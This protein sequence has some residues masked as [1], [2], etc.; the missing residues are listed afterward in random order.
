MGVAGLFPLFCLSGVLVRRF[1]ELGTRA[2]FQRWGGIRTYTRG[3]SKGASCCTTICMVGRCLSSR[4]FCNIRVARCIP[5]KPHSAASRG[6]CCARQCPL[7]RAFRKRRHFYFNNQKFLVCF[8]VL[9]DAR[10]SRG[11]SGLLFGRDSQLPQ[12]RDERCRR[13]IQH[14]LRMSRCTGAARGRRTW[15]CARNG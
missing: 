1:R 11:T 10:N 8:F 13:K 2:R 12:T 5:N 7:A 3:I 4:T 15:R 6:C 9:L 14:A